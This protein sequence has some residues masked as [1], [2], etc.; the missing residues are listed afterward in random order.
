MGIE[1]H[2]FDNMVSYKLETVSSLFTLYITQLFKK[3]KKFEIN[4]FFKLH[5]G[6]IIEQSKGT[7]HNVETKFHKFS[8]REILR[9]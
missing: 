9:C 4:F 3:L 8:L 1:R 6:G 2:S 7:S 5:L